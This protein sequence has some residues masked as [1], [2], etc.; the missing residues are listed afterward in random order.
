[1]GDEVLTIITTLN[2]S[3]EFCEG[4]RSRALAPPTA[5]VDLTWP[6]I[7]RCDGVPWVAHATGIN[8]Q[9]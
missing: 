5:P 1:M 8:L 9:A 3:D 2:Q 7:K 6:R 4:L